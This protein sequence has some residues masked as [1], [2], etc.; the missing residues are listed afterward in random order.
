M[1]QAG[2]TSAAIELLETISNVRE[3]ADVVISEYFRRRRYAGSG[4]RRFI[5]NLVYSSLRHMGFL[6]WQLKENGADSNNSRNLMIANIMAKNPS[7]LENIFSDNRFSA[8][9][10][11]NK[12]VQLAQRLESQNK[13]NNAPQWAKLNCPEWLLE[14]FITNFPDTYK[15]ELE[16][17]NISA[18]IDLRVNELK[19][20][21]ELVQ[22]YLKDDGYLFTPTPLSL[23]GLRSSIW[24][25]LLNTKSYRDGLFQIQDEGSQMIASAV[26]AKPGEKIA[27]LCAGAG[28]KSLALAAIMKNEGQI[29][30]ADISSSRLNRIKPRIKR[31]GINIINTAPFDASALA[32]A[33]DPQDRV[34][35]D[36]PCSGTGTWRRHPEAR[37]RL[38]SDQLEEY[39][40]VQA[41]LLS[42]GAKLVRP[43]GWVIY[44]TCS[45]LK[46]ENEDQVSA[47]LNNHEEFFRLPVKDYLDDYQLTLSGLDA[48]SNL[49]LSPARNNTDGVFVAVFEKA[50]E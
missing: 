6:T 11:N 20:S 48:E 42:D 13:L 36:A 14:K 47:F 45:L 33:I 39:I 8:G 27:D 50:S 37:W 17:L 30:A 38:N 23:V 7:E 31:A 19:T 41:N 22:A 21:R 5:R 12:E 40:K 35:I 24:Y 1:N 43:G 49:S 29:I 44:A 15:N 9:N 46:D 26:N 25:P 28:G 4:D 18:P 32:Q 16:A 10:L 2:R 3:P 34:L